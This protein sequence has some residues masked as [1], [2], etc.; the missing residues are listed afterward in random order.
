MGYLIDTSFK[1]ID[2]PLAEKIF[3]PTTVDI[4]EEMGIINPYGD[5]IYQNDGSIVLKRKDQ[6]VMKIK[7]KTIIPSVR[8]CLEFDIVRCLD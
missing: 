3:K 4:F 8:Y 2:L 6:W 1:L 5:F 7:R